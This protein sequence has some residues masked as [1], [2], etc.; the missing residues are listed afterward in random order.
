MVS[1]REFWAAK[2]RASPRRRGESFTDWGQ[3]LWDE[4]GEFHPRPFDRIQNEFW[5]GLQDTETPRQRQRVPRQR[6]RRM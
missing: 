2:A 3:R 6:I 1:E 4:H 5:L